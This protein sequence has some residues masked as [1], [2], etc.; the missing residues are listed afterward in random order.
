MGILTPSTSLNGPTT[1]AV[2]AQMV[3]SAAP[4]FEDTLEIYLYV[5]I[6]L[7]FMK[8]FLLIDFF[9]LQLLW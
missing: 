4:D 5:L 1:T 8:V 3:S 9:Q 6:C 7:L 2:Q